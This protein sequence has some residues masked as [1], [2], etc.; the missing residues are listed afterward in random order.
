MGSIN[1][2]KREDREVLQ[3]V[4]CSSLTPVG[5]VVVACQAQP[6]YDYPLFNIAVEFDMN[7]IV[8]TSD[9]LRQAFS[10]FLEQYENIEKTMK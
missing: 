2:S 10:N 7:D 4:Y 9:V 1:G 3:E 5:R 8:P 6:D